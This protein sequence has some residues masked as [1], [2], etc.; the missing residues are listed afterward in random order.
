MNYASRKL[1]ST[2]LF[3]HFPFPPLRDSAM[4]K[5]MIWKAF[6]SCFA[7][8]LKIQYSQALLNTLLMHL[9]QF[10]LFLNMT[11]GVEHTYLWAVSPFTFCNSI[12][13]EGCT[14]IFRSLHRCSFRCGCVFRF[15]LLK[16]EPTSLQHGS[17]TT[18]RHC[19]DGIG[20]LGFLQTLLS[21]IDGKEFNLCLI[22]PENFLSHR[23]RGL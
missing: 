10:H 5:M 9:W 3:T 4:S 14:A 21:G 15:V 13:L 16:D 8:L 23:L 17:V 6:F 18:V 2:S 22:R 7:H 20:L 12:R 1:H 11:P 19:R